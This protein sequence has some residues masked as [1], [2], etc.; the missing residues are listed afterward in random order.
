MRTMSMFWVQ[1]LLAASEAAQQAAQQRFAHT[2]LLPLL[3]TAAT[4]ACSAV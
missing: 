2:A 1:G 3:R 4:E